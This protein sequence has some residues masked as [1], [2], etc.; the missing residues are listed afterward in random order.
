MPSA[1]SSIARGHGIKSQAHLVCIRT[2][3]LPHKMACTRDQ[4]AVCSRRYESIPGYV[5]NCGS[6]LRRPNRDNIQSTRTL[7]PG[8]LWHHKG[9]MDKTWL[10]SVLK[11]SALLMARILFRCTSSSIMP[12]RCNMVFREY[13]QG[14]AC[15]AQ[16]TCP[17]ALPLFKSHI[18]MRVCIH[19]GPR[20]GVGRCLSLR[21][22]V[23]TSNG[24]IMIH[25]VA[26][27]SVFGV[28]GSA[29]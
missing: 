9:K 19:S 13:G 1:E 8:S 28:F 12:T 26:V 18:Q 16:P 23:W 3:S 2:L 11:S 10:P 25:K 22:H 21:H 29:R 5:C 4:Q 6:K 7:C 27:R 17:A 24:A 14:I 20:A 15:D